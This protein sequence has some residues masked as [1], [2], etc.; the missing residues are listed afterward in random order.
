[1]LFSEGCH[2]VDRVIDVFGKP[3]KVTGF[4]RH[5]SP[6]K[7]GLADN[8]LAV[9][10]CASAIAAVSVAAFQPNR[11]KYRRLEIVGSNGVA[12]V[13]PYSPQHDLV[14]QEALCQAC[15]ML[16]KSH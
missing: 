14:R 12:R 10:E 5:E 3:L 16:D 9:F 8:G 4:L 1:M 2:L 6:L 7:D 11:G 15:E 13:E